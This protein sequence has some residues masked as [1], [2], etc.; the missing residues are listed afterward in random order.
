MKRLQEPPRGRGHGE[1]RLLRDQPM[2]GKTRK[3]GN[4]IRRGEP[5]VRSRSEVCDA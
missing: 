1:V 3:G 4:V 5:D 2:F